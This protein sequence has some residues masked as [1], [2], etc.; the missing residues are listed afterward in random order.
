[1]IVTACCCCC[2]CSW[3]KWTRTMVGIRL[4]SILINT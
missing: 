4:L 2:C 1:M 3:H